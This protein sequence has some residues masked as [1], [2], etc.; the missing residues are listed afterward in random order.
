MVIANSCFNLYKS[1]QFIYSHCY[2]IQS[3]LGIED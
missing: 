3:N 1:G 2:S